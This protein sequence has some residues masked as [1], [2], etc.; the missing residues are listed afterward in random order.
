MPIL[1]RRDRDGAAFADS[2]DDFDERDVWDLSLAL[3]LLFRA[4]SANAFLP[5]FRVMAKLHFD[6]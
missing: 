3:A 6:V 1:R 2:L 5:V 4:D